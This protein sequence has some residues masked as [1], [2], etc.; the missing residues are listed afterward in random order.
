MDYGPRAGW[1]WHVPAIDHEAEHNREV[2]RRPRRQHPLPSFLQ[3]GA[4]NRAT[5][6]RK[7]FV[8]RPPVPRTR[9]RQADH[10][11]EQISQIDDDQAEDRG[12]QRDKSDGKFGTVIDRVVALYEFAGQ[13]DN[14]LSFKVGDTIE[15]TRNDNAGWWAGHLLNNPPS[16]LWFPALYVG[17]VIDITAKASGTLAALRERVDGVSR[18]LQALQ[19]N[20]EAANAWEERGGQLTTLAVQARGILNA[21]RK[22]VDGMSSD[23][24]A[25]DEEDRALQSRV[26]NVQARVIARE[27]TIKARGVLTASRESLDDVASDLQAFKEKERTLRESQSHTNESSSDEDGTKDDSESDTQH[28]FADEKEGTTKDSKS[29]TNNSTPP[30]TEDGTRDDS[31]SDT[32]Q[33]GLQ[34]TTIADKARGILNALRE[35]VDGV[36]NNLRALQAHGEAANAWKERGIQL[37]T[38]AV[39]ARH[40]LNALR[41]RVDGVSSDLKALE[42][43]ERALQSREMNVQARII[44]REL[45]TAL[46]FWATLR[47]ALTIKARG[48]L[49]ASRES[50]DDVASDLQAL[51]EKER[52]LRESQSHTNESSADEDGTKDDSESDTQHG[53]ADEKEG[54]TKDSKSDTNNSTPPETED[55]TRDDSGS[56]TQQRG[57][58]LTTI[59]DK[60]RGILNALRERVDGVS[61][62]LRA[63]QAH[64]EAANAWKERGIQ[65]TTI[66]VQARH[67]LNALRKRVDG[68]SSDLKALEEK[69]RAL[70]SREM[71]VQARII[72]RELSTA[73]GFWATLRRALTI[74]ARGVLTASRESLDDVAS[75]LRLQQNRTPDFVETDN[76]VDTNFQGSNDTCDAKWNAEN[77]TLRTGGTPATLTFPRSVTQAAWDAA[78]RD[79]CDPIQHEERSFTMVDYAFDDR[80]T[81]SECIPCVV[82]F[83]LL[84]GL[85]ATL[86]IK[87]EGSATWQ[88]ANTRKLQTYNIRKA[89]VELSK[90]VDKVVDIGDIDVD[91]RL[92]LS[93]ENRGDELPTPEKESDEEVYAR[94]K[95]VRTSNLV[96]SAEYNTAMIEAGKML[97]AAGSSSSNKWRDFYDLFL[98]EH[99]AWWAE[100][101]V[102]E[103]F[104]AKG[105]VRIDLERRVN[106]DKAL[107][108]RLHTSNQTKSEELEPVCKRLSAIAS[109]VA[110]LKNVHGKPLNQMFSVK[111]LIEDIDKVLSRMS[112]KTSREKGESD[113][114]KS[115]AAGLDDEAKKLPPSATNDVTVTPKYYANAIKALTNNTSSSE[116]WKQICEKETST[117]ANYRAWEL[118]W[119]PSIKQITHDPKR[120]NHNR[121]VFG[122]DADTWAASKKGKGSKKDKAPKVKITGYELFVAIF[123]ANSGLAPLAKGEGKVGDTYHDFN[124]SLANVRFVANGKNAKTVWGAVHVIRKDA[125]ESQSHTNESSSAADGTTDDSDG[126]THWSSADEG[127][128]I[129]SDTHWSSAD[130]EPEDET[131]DV[132]SEE[133]DETTE[134]TSSAVR[135]GNYIGT[136]YRGTRWGV[137][138]MVSGTATVAGV[139]KDAFVATDN[140]A[141]WLTSNDRTAGSYSNSSPTQAAV[142]N[143]TPAPSSIFPSLPSL[144]SLFTGGDDGGESAS[145]SDGGGGEAAQPP[146]PSSIFPS[147]PSLSSLFTGGDDGGGGEAAQPPTPSQ[148]PQARQL[149]LLPAQAQPL[150]PQQAQPPQPPQA[151]QL[152]PPPLQPPQPP[153]PRLRSGL[154]PV[155]YAWRDMPRP[156][157]IA[158]L[159]QVRTAYNI[160]ILLTQ[161][162][163]DMRQIL[164]RLF[165]EGK[166]R[167]D[168]QGQPELVPPNQTHLY[169]M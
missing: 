77:G 131:K 15:V 73:L 114:D 96:L 67:I 123:M 95:I 78:A 72:A 126:D 144:S 10:D 153:T 88:V 43:K 35:R 97:D 101:S 48:V 169:P 134:A 17:K 85:H 159:G 25:L 161:R 66:A 106:K 90:R 5:S 62:N 146:T 168:A 108:E 117:Y 2:F 46:G 20:G 151:L 56:D 143:P 133:K 8:R 125:G 120:G 13:N 33:R 44:A 104:K 94:L 23:L 87:H 51:E 11:G 6:T 60:A 81:P 99:C 155:E 16:G 139:F 132:E 19:T 29:D 64:G 54:T 140:V 18:D 12:T 160:S 28:G 107:L 1:G 59:A 105:H 22:R 82:D 9:Q 37:T 45:S 136:A 93:A 76:A 164:R 141:R 148:P 122:D 63:L 124:G 75:D 21:L 166:I 152:Q 154:R 110:S 156:D 109:D 42:E 26:M 47:R 55:G 7:N 135:A 65:L 27:L 165:K 119:K 157:M 111:N 50:L 40:I 145:G 83:P 115:S 127:D 102:R 158:L 34:L 100:E 118:K 121:I 69:E 58:Q 130:E 129:E 36:S 71:N 103:M 70:Q 86:E 57:L 80:K 41:K 150:P 149:P 61:N 38:I 116:I 3:Q 113:T 128:D 74:K 79:D 147:L 14:E 167:L 24:K 91:I 49:T 52:V 92:L 89:L 30:E 137:S 39:Q 163:M 98:I 32:Q 112:H 53:F 31:G 138:T 84:L 162:S 142:K 68:V 4:K